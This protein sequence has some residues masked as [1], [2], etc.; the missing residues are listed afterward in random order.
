[1]TVLL[2]RLKNDVWGLL[3]IFVGWV[4]IFLTNIPINFLII[5]VVTILGYILGEVIRL[6]IWQSK[7]SEK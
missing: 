4:I 1:M 2:K 6:L 3:V 5:F 7:T